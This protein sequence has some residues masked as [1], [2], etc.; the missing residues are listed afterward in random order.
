MTL[1]DTPEMVDADDIMHI[2]KLDSAMQ[3]KVIEYLQSND[4]VKYLLAEETKKNDDKMWVG[5]S[6][7]L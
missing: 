5:I 4:K 6:L 1:A 7:E 3:K 2:E